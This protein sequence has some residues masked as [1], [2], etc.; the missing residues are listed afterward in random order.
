MKDFAI[1][2]YC[3]LDDYLKRSHTKEDVKRK[4]SNAEVL[5]TAIIVA[6]YFCENFVKARHYVLTPIMNWK[7][8]TKNL[9]RFTSSLREKVI[10]KDRIIQF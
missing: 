10:L 7:T 9:N 2:I 1:A 5:V 4:M 6:R 3:F 8:T